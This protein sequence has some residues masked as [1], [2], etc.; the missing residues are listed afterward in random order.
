MHR[1]RTGRHGAGQVGNE[2]QGGQHALCGKGADRGDCSFARRKPAVRQ[3]A[4]RDDAG[5]GVVNAILRLP[6]RFSGGLFMRSPMQGNY[7]VKAA[8][9]CAVSRESLLCRR[10]LLFIEK[11]SDMV[12]NKFIQIKK[13]VI[14]ISFCGTLY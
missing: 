10:D 8:Q 14:F 4:G 1:D 2:R 6:G 3:T 5:Y 9:G 11:I 7:A 13:C 12:Y